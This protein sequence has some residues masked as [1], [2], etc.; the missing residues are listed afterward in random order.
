M[1]R[2]Q[3]FSQ[4]SEK[5]LSTLVKA[6]HKTE[7]QEGEYVFQQGVTGDTFFVITEGEAEVVRPFLE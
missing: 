7:F 2:P 6:M 5:Q 1:H 3:A 4:L